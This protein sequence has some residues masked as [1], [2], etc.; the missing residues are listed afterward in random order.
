MDSSK[1]GTKERCSRCKEVK[2]IAAE[3]LGE[4]DLENNRYYC[5][6][7]YEQLHKDI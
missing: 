3:D 7:C 1:I 2:F 5:A 6:G 4:R